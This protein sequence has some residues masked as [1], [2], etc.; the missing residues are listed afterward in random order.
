MSSDKC[1]CSCSGEGE[2]RC[3]S[4]EQPCSDCNKDNVVKL[5]KKSVPSKLEQRR[6]Q[7]NQERIRRTMN[8]SNCTEE[9]A[10]KTLQNEDF[11]ALP[12]EQK[13]KLLNSGCNK[14]LQQV[15]KDIGALNYNICAVV[16]AMEA[17]SI[18]HSKIFEKL[19][20]SKE[21]QAEINRAVIADMDTAAKL[22][23]EQGKKA[24]AE[25]EESA[26]VNS[27]LSENKESKI[28]GTGIPEE[29]TIFG[30]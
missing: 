25:L 22:R 29:A 4:M 24:Q 26:T 16:N 1:E 13:F 23:E 27:L 2:C 12:L 21:E 5:E 28:T 8:K 11:E 20:I 15:G 7:Q 30:E 17:T 19:G 10:T 9:E 6:Q 14:V 18:A 3:G